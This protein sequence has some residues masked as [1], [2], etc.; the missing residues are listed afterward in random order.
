M[1]SSNQSCCRPKYPTFYFLPNDDDDCD[2]S[3][4]ASLKHSLQVLKMYQ[5]LVAET[6]AR[7][8]EAEVVFRERQ[9]QQDS[10]SRL[11]CGPTSA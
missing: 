3:Q 8:S 7:F 5:T 10:F 9:Q 6:D 11:H 2:E 4:P 1:T